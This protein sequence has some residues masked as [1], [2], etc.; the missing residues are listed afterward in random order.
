[1]VCHTNYRKRQVNIVAPQVESDDEKIDD[2]E[3]DLKDNDGDQMEED[4]DDGNQR[5]ISRY[6]HDVALLFCCF[7]NRILLVLVIK[8]LWLH[9]RER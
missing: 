1:M 3:E 6:D 9:F 5:Y 4:D 8:I 7:F 2:D